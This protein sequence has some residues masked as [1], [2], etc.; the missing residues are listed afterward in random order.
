MF[1]LIAT[2]AAKVKGWMVGAALAIGVVVIAY[3][4]G[5]QAATQNAKLKQANENLNAIKTAR[6]VENEVAGYDPAKLD[7]RLSRWVRDKQ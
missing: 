1:S 7:A 6:S 4:E 5:R 2:L 3:I